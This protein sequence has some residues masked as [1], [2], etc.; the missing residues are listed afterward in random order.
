[1]KAIETLGKV[2]EKGQL[3]LTSPLN[4][5]NKPVRVIIL[6]QEE[7]SEDDQWL[8]ALSNNPSFDFLKEPEEDIYTLED[9]K[10]FKE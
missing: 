6:I 4:F 10:P 9:G 1:M 2:D 8:N 7:D 3:H 5:K